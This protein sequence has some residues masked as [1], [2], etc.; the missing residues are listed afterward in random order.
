MIGFI[1]RD[2]ACGNTLLLDVYSGLTP[3]ERRVHNLKMLQKYAALRSM[4]QTRTFA[5]IEEAKAA[6]CATRAKT[7]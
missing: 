6:Y 1:E 5:T 3:E 4:L 7:N 2:V